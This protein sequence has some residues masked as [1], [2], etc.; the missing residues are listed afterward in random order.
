[1]DFKLTADGD[2]AIENGDFVFVRGIEA[3]QQD[4]TM[5]LRT[6]FRETPYDRSVGV[7]WLEVIFERGVTI[8]AI[9]FILTNIILGVDGATDVL[10]LDVA[11]DREA[12]EA[13]I[14][15]RV[16]AL[17]QEFPFAVTVSEGDAAA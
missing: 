10:D 6:F 1:M 11:I 17:D 9:R 7:P 2:I 15:G 5:T 12:R 8:D 16:K 3:V 4:I 13:T 14:T